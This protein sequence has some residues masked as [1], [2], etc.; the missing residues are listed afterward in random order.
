M[1][2]TSLGLRPANRLPP[3]VL[4]HPRPLPQGDR[5][6]GALGRALTLKALIVLVVT[7]CF[8]LVAAIVAASTRRFQGW[9]IYLTIA[10]V[11]VGL[12]IVIVIALLP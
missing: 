11:V 10:A 6:N 7:W 2:G 9:D 8:L 5:G 12:A 4:H 3:A 1:S